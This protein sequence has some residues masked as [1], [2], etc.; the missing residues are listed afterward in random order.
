MS[1][2]SP[3]MAVAE[4]HIVADLRDST[5]L[6]DPA[7]AAS[8]TKDRGRLRVT[9]S[10]SCYCRIAR[11]LFCSLPADHN[12]ESSDLFPVPA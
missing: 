5:P 8:P 10:D 7:A 9:G 6:I 11:L 2:D 3:K 12:V 1:A 4:S